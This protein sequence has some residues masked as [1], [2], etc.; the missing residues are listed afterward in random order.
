[1]VPVVKSEVK[2]VHSTVQEEILYFTN[3]EKTS[4]APMEIEE[5][6]MPKL[7]GYSSPPVVTTFVRVGYIGQVAQCDEWIKVNDGRLAKWNVMSH[8]RHSDLRVRDEVVFLS[9][10]HRDEGMEECGRYGCNYANAF[11]SIHFARLVDSF[12]EL[13]GFKRVLFIVLELMRSSSPDYVNAVLPLINMVGQLKRVIKKEYLG[14]FTPDFVDACQKLFLN[15]T[16]VNVRQ[17]ASE[18]VEIALSSLE[19]LIHE[20]YGRNPDATGVIEKLRLS[21]GIRYFSCPYLNRRLGGLKILSDLVRRA[22]NAII[23][24]V[25]ISTNWPKDSGGLSL[26]ILAVVP[27]TY[28]LTGKH[29]CTELINADV[30]GQLYK[31]SNIHESLMARSAP[32]LQALAKEDLLDE[33]LLDTLLKACLTKESSLPKVLVEI[34]GCLSVEKMKIALTQ[35][36]QFDNCSVNDG[37]LSIVNALALKCRNY[38]MTSRSSPDSVAKNSIARPSSLFHEVHTI[39]LNILWNWVVETSDV[40]NCVKLVCVDKLETLVETGISQAAALEDNYF[41]WAMQWYRVQELLKQSVIALTMRQSIIP[42]IKVLQAFLYSWPSKLPSSKDETPV[43]VPFQPMRFAAA[44]YI[45]TTFNAFGVVSECITSLKSDASKNNAFVAVLSYNTTYVQHIELLLDFMNNLFRSVEKTS[46]PKEALYKIWDLLVLRAEVVDEFDLA[47]MFMSKIPTRIINSSADSIESNS[48]MPIYGAKDRWLEVYFDLICANHDSG[49]FNSDFFSLKTLKAIEKWFRW[50]NAESNH[51][52]DSREGKIK[53][54]FVDLTELKGIDAFLQIIFNCS[55]DSNAVSCVNFVINLIQIA[56]DRFGSKFRSQLL[57]CCLQHIDENTGKVQLHRILLL[58]N[59]LVEESFITSKH[60]IYAHNFVSQGQSTTFKISASSKTLNCSGDD[61]VLR[62]NDTIE[63]LFNAV[64]KF[65]HASPSDIKLFRLGKEIFPGEYKKMIA[66]LPMISDHSTIVVT[67]RSQSSKRGAAHNPDIGVSEHNVALSL[68]CSVDSCNS[69]LDLLRKSTA[70][71][72]DCVWNT[73]S[74]IPTFY[75]LLDIWYRLDCSCIADLCFPLTTQNF[76]KVG[77]LVYFLQIIELLISHSISMQQLFGQ[78]EAIVPDC[79]TDRTESNWIVSFLEKKGF[80]FLLT[81]YEWIYT[82]MNA[83]M[84]GHSIMGISVELGL[85]GLSLLNKIIRASMVITNLNNPEYAIFVNIFHDKMGSRDYGRNENSNGS[86]KHDV[87]DLTGD[88]QLVQQVKANQLSGIEK[89]WGVKAHPS[90]MILQCTNWE[91]LHWCSWLSI[92]LVQHIILSEINDKSGAEMRGFSS[93]ISR[94]KFL[95][96]TMNDMLF[97]STSV[98]ILKSYVLLQQSYKNR[99]YGNNGNFEA[100]I[101]KGIL[102]IGSGFPSYSPGFASW[103]ANGL[104]LYSDWILAFN[105]ISCYEG[106]KLKDIPQVGVNLRAHLLNHL[107]AKRPSIT[108]VKTLNTDDSDE[109]RYAPLFS[110]AT[111]LLTYSSQHLNYLR[112]T[113]ST[114][115]SQSFVSPEMRRE[116]CETIIGEL[117]TVYAS[118]NNLTPNVEHMEGNMLLLVALVNTQDKFVIG[119]FDQTVVEFLIYDVL[120]LVELNSCFNGFVV[121]DKIVR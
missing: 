45:V 69:L 15:M 94:Q 82:V 47:F 23:Y 26:P 52:S 106:S 18:A 111:K 67:E 99:S 112:G 29:I 2:T 116:L 42:S 56:G 31:D 36:A 61:V 120:G 7:E 91:S 51:L 48:S 74:R 72:V 78:Y 57:A 118:N 17:T 107:F 50:V 89:E 12:G 55:G 21:I 53:A 102:N 117:K 63:D 71:D 10:V 64:G 110:L 114:V 25:G 13:G 100:L 40:D 49:Y 11:T 62:L 105:R 9:I 38:L 66:Q 14:V 88:T 28:A 108:R 65:V 76:S 59:G 92:L 109:K 4:I 77:E 90:S 113:A 68:V 86:S 87:I 22:S 27:I 58:L 1:M 97:T 60:R 3:D 84:N 30:F 6:E 70:S 119:A 96:N 85:L 39:A 93:T 75:H 41:P 46:I 44:D 16:H 101:N 80:E 37:I 103:L 79:A 121:K 81:S 20:T 104:C 35:I 115:R 43:E 83:F 34:I 32:I 5:D 19:E 73:I 24:P 98:G 33:A 54:I 95:T 8:G